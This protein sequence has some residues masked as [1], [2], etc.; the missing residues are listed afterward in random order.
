MLF[1]NF[2]E[3][4][5]GAKWTDEWSST[6]DDRCPNCDTS[7]SPVSSEDESGNQTADDYPRRI[8]PVLDD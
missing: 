1:R 4:P 3:C 8:S 2:Y 6:C 7:C 5:C